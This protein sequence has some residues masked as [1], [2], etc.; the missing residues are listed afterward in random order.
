M[1]IIKTQIEIIKNGLYIAF[2]LGISFGAIILIIYCGSI[3]YFPSGV[4]VGDAFLFAS[5]ALSFGLVCASVIILFQL[6]SMLIY[7][8]KYLS[9]PHGFVYILAV[10]IFCFDFLVIWFVDSPASKVLSLLLSATFPILFISRIRWFKNHE[11]YDS[12]SDRVIT[13]E[14]S[15]KIYS[16]SFLFSFLIIFIYIKPLQQLLDYS[17]KLI[18]IRQDAVDVHISDKYVDLLKHEGVQP[19]IDGKNVFYDDVNI[20]FQGVGENILIDIH[21]VKLSIP[22]SDIFILKKTNEPPHQQTN[23]EC[24]CLPH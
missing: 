16:A 20:L 19:V 4:S 23:Q 13:E 24:C 22:K 14:P 17:M 18:A 11:S 8:K 6:P 9:L 12:D 15:F 21:C 10:S 7:W 5:V 3:G 1:E 2:I